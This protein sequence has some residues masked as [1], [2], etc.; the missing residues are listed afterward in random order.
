MQR[1]EMRT[2]SANSTPLTLMEVKVGRNFVRPLA[3][4]WLSV[5]TLID[6]VFC[7]LHRACFTVPPD[8]QET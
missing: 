8:S 7:V 4:D 1:T 2:R 3:S 5:R 6:D